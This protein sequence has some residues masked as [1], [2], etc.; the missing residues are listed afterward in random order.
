[1]LGSLKI[2]PLQ[3]GHP[4]P[5]VSGG[6]LHGLPERT[7]L[8]DLPIHLFELVDGIAFDM[9]LDDVDALAVVGEIWTVAF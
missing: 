5:K 1:M 2:F 4:Y 7:G 3:T 9:L 6:Q 8:L